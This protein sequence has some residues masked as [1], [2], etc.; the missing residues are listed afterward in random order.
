MSAE[1]ES[2]HFVGVQLL[3][4]TSMIN[5]NSPIQNNEHSLSTYADDAKKAF[6]D[7]SND[8]QEE[9]LNFINN[10]SAEYNPVTER[11]FVNR[12][13]R[14]I[15]KNIKNSQEVQ[16]GISEM[17]ADNKSFQHSNQSSNIPDFNTQDEW[18]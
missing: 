2:S 9:V 14:E 18:N 7:L 13:G 5:E 1:L 11:L 4:T 12:T 3:I 17:S 8:T 16:L 6:F 10:A 15:E